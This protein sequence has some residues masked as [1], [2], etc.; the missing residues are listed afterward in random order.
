[1]GGGVGKGV[2]KGEGDSVGAGVG[3]GVGNV[4][5]EGLIG[6]EAGMVTCAGRVATDTGGSDVAMGAPAVGINCSL[7]AL[8]TLNIV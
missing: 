3:E 7:S 2:G 5:G 6:G 8:H 1:M 4:V